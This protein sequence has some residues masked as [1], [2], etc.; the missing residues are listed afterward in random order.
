MYILYIAEPFYYQ[1]KN[2]PNYYFSCSHDC[3]IALN[4]GTKFNLVPGLTGE[5]G[6]VSFQSADN[7]R[8]YLHH[9]KFLVLLDSKT[10]SSR[11]DIFDEDATFRIIKNKYFHGFDS[12]QSVN[13]PTHYLRSEA[14]TKE[15]RIIPKKFV[16]F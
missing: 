9:H 6:T 7:P 16:N 10:T 12:F 5:A 8:Y 13:F 15:I 1:A 4:K 3:T 14:I 11:A 2:Y